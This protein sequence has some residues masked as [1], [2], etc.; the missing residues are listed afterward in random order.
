MSQSVIPNLQFVTNA[1]ALHYQ[2]SPAELIEHTLRRGEGTFADSGALAVSTGTFTGRS[3]KDKFVV[4]DANT[5]P[6]VW[7]GTVNNPFPEEAFNRLLLRVQAYLQ[8]RE[9]YVR[10][11]YAGADPQYR[12]KVRVINESPWQNLF[13]NN[14]FI[15]PAQ[16]ELEGFAPDF[17]VIAAPGFQADPAIDGTRAANFTIV[18]F[19]HKLILIGG[20]AYTGEIKK[21]IFSVLNYLLPF[22]NVLPM[23]CSAN[24]GAA[25]D[26]AIFFGLSGTGKTT[27]SA[28]PA[29]NLIGDD[30]HGWTPNGVFNFE[31]GCYAKCI[32]LSAEK[33]PQIWS[34]IRFGTLL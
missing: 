5:L 29:R 28:D 33:E 22:Q 26:V 1:K 6:H 24:V 32:D 23:H 31:G 18:N 14:L 17:T 4:E 12:L 19:T 34:A 27:L 15:R 8:S 21:G 16:N 10:D 20:S 13:V 3:P 9:L 25:G 2:L 30:E 7:W 11:A